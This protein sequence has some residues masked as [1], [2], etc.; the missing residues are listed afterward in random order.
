MF[1]DL[2]KGFGGFNMC[3][4]WQIVP[5]LQAQVLASTPHCLCV[6]FEGG[7][8][9]PA[10]IHQS[11]PPLVSRHNRP[12]NVTAKTT[13]VVLKTEASQQFH[14]ISSAETTTTSDDFSQQGVLFSLWRFIS[15]PARGEE[16]EENPFPHGLP[17]SLCT[18]DGVLTGSVL[19]KSEG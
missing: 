3:V 19:H 1:S 15:N 2:S 12:H 14:L 13:C 7:R 16:E 17:H 18:E 10:T 4:Y 6:A 8:L 9:P 5:Q 11:P